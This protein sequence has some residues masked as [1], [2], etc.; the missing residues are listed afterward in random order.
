MSSNVD[1][2]TD[3]IAGKLAEHRVNLMRVA[4]HIST[5]VNAILTDLQN[6]IIYRLRSTDLTSFQQF[7]L[8]SLLTDIGNEIAYSMNEASTLID[9]N[10]TDVSG[11]EALVVAQ[12][13]NS[14]LGMDVMNGDLPNET[15][16]QIVDDLMVQG[17]PIGDYLNQQGSDLQFRIAQQLRM[18]VA[19]D[20][21]MSELEDR[22]IGAGG[23]PGVFGKTNSMM[24][25]LVGTALAT[26]VNDTRS[27]VYDQNDV[28]H[29]VWYTIMD[30]DECPECADL[31]G[32]VDPDD[33]PP[34]HPNCRCDLV[35]QVAAEAQIE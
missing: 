28:A 26:V 4:A 2:T 9:E 32:E 22:I 12:I 30:G 19:A 6:E 1:T 13:I 11:T 21:S 34:L 24:D 3:V 31:N 17:A 16:Q 33:E 15:T 5:L 8:A 7:K 23:D 25:L 18:G 35:P 14:V 20:D 10:M 29:M 27:A